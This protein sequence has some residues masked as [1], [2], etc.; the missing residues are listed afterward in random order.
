M[1]TMSL[2]KDSNNWDDFKQRLQQLKEGVDPRHLVESLGF[3]ISRETSRE[4]RGPC[5]I[6]GGDNKTSFRFN[7][8]ARSWVCFSHRCHENN[9]SDII[10]LIMS[11]TGSS[12]KEAVDYLHKLCGESG[13][14]MSQAEYAHRQEKFDFIKRHREDSATPAIVK[15]EHLESFKRYRSN[16]F[17]REGF[18]REVLDHFEIAGGYTDSHEIIRDIIPIR[19]EEGVLTAYSLRDIRP[20]APDDDFKYILTKGFVKDKVLYN[21]YNVK[22][23][24]QNKP[25]IV[26]E[27]FKSVWRLYQYGITNSVAVMGSKITPGQV[28]LLCKYALK[29]IIVMFDNDVAGVNGTID[30]VRELTGKLSVRPIFITETDDNGKGLD[31]ADLSKEAIYNYLGKGE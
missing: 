3:T 30:A 13:D 16:L 15:E 24:A 2:Y 28:N 5:K 14:F 26:V 22:E 12:F 25:L 27:G 8:Q 6:H 20:N 4:L 29:G 31:P 9:G 10:G 18:T 19:D 7:K 21:L 17:L 11:V 23:E 1:K